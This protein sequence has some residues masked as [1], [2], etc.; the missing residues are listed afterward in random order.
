MKFF[1]SITQVAIDPSF[2]QGLVESS[3]WDVKV[4]VGNIRIYAGYS[5]KGLRNS[6]GTFRS[7][8]DCLC[9]RWGR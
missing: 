9:L 3:H 5:K 4:S 8:M 7:A 1:H 2:R 6:S